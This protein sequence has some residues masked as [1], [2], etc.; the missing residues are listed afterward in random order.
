MGRMLVSSQNS[1]VA[2]RTPVEASHW[3]P[4]H[5]AGPLIAAFQPPEPRETHFYCFFAAR[6]VVVC[7][8][9]L[10]RPAQPLKTESCFRSFHDKIWLVAKF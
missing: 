10:N 7:Y 5:H 2:M 9:S 6:P 4:A 8:R 3:N 1:D